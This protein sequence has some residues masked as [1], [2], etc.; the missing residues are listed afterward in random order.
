MIVGKSECQCQTSCG[1]FDYG[2]RGG[3]RRFACSF[4]EFYDFIV[5]ICMLN[6]ENG[7]T[8]KVY[9]LLVPMMVLTMWN[10]WRMVV[11]DWIIR[12]V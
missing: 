2:I 1:G 10:F 11:G 12:W 9:S 7:A 8:Q 5:Q 3:G 4:D 6:I